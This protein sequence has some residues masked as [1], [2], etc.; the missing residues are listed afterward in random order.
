LQQLTVEE[1]ITIELFEG[2]KYQTKN[3]HKINNA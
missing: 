2:G 3:T 1:E